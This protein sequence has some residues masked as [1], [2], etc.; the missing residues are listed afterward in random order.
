MT[1][2]PVLTPTTD[3]ALISVHAFLKAATAEAHNRIESR[4]AAIFD[5]DQASYGR[6]LSVSARAVISLEHL[7]SGSNTPVADWKA[8]SRT[9]AIAADLADLGIAVPVPARVPASASK[10]FLFGILYV[11]EGSRLGARQLARAAQSSPSPSVRS[12]TRYLRHGQSG[13][14][15][16]SFI[17]KLEAAHCVR[18]DPG[19]TARGALS[20]FRVF[21]AAVDRP[22]V[23]GVG[24]PTETTEG[25]Q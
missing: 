8:R 21:E 23:D 14:L 12:A 15:W 18:S 25:V 6:F 19:E 13:R 7:I 10:S 24:F 20:A 4:Y 9:A 5:V 2:F 1:A 11:L 22:V 3:G 17:E 16:P